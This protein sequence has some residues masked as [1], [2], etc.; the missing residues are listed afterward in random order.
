MAGNLY[1]IPNTLGDSNI[2]I[3]I[4]PEVVEIIKSIDVFI[5]ENIR[6]ARRYLIKCGYSSPIDNIKFLELN[7]HTQKNE[8]GSY[9]D[10]CLKGHDIGLIS[11]AGVPGVADPGAEIT[12]IAHE[13]SIRVIPLTGPSSILLSLMASGLNGQ[14]FVFHGYLPLKPNERSRRIKEIESTAFN[15][16]QTQIFIETPYRNVS[17]FDSLLKTCK[18]YTRLCIACDI[19]LENEFIKTLSISAW[20][21][22]RVNLHKRPCIFLIGK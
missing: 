15:V 13:K 21:K 10:E 6:N 2:N 14:N 1:L 18:P 11:E 19:S 17:M 9:L 16:H 12:S 20:K 4:P 3:V 5:I 7:K 8:I 22:E